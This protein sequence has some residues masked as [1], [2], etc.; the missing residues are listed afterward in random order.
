[1]LVQL[2]EEGASL[3]G[4]LS[5]ID[6]ICIYIQSYVRNFQGVI[7]M[8]DD[9]I[10]AVKIAATQVPPKYVATVTFRYFYWMDQ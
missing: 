8:L 6:D 3:Q 1:M 10:N 9:S 4:C 5:S 7:A 2:Q